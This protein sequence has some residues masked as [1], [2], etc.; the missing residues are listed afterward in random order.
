M[1]CDTD[2]HVQLLISHKFTYRGQ[3]VWKNNRLVRFESKTDDN[4]KLFTVSAIAEAAGLRVRVNNEEKIVKP[5]AWL[6]S[7]WTLPDP[8]LRNQPLV[9]LDADNAKVFNGQLG[10][11]GLEKLKIAGQEVPLNHY[12]ITG[13]LTIDLWYDGTERLVRQEWVEQ[14]HKTLIELIRVRK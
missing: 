10:Y 13:D 14:G 5:E 12:R 4:K 7:Y 1:R 9:I 6:T 2:V 8:K 3:E 11:V